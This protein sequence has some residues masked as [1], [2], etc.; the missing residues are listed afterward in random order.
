MGTQF[1]SI[2]REPLDNYQVLETLGSGRYGTASRVFSRRYNCDFCM[3]VIR[4]DSGP[5]DDLRAMFFRETSVLRKVGHPNVVR[6]YDFYET[7]TT[8]NIVMEHCPHG[9][10]NSLCEKD[11][12]IPLPR[13]RK[14]FRQ[15]IDAI[16]CF[17]SIKI[18]HRDI[19][20]SNI[21]LDD[22]DRPKIIDWGFSTVC[23]DGEMSRT[24]CGTFPYVAPECLKKIPYDPKISD[25]WSIGVTMYVMAFG[26]HPFE[27]QYD[28]I[29]IE[30][31]MRGEY[32]IPPTDLP[33]R[34]LLASLMTVEPKERMTAREALSHPFF[35]VA[36][37][38]IKLG[39]AKL[40]HH[41]SASNLSVSSW[42]AP[43]TEGSGKRAVFAHVMFLR[44]TRLAGQL[45]TQSG[46]RSEKKR[47]YPYH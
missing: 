29:A 39:Q 33:F 41:Q 31:A 20:P 17:H 7:P 45:R 35:A 14:L 13:L 6:L 46:R 22:G 47:E 24:F 2:M 8:F 37:E 5:E 3:K 10:L 16:A 19:K 21:A 44:P 23:T 12:T 15:I 43:G 34:S 36:D 27:N 11:K 40:P 9:T 1:Q 32:T 38:P 4:K 30:K 26:H 28:T 25:M 42:A 18:A